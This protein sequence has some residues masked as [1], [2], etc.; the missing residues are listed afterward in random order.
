MY[1]NIEK[2]INDPNSGR[3]VKLDENLNFDI[4]INSGVT[5]GN[6]PIKGLI[7]INRDNIIVDGSNSVLNFNIYNT[8]T[9]DWSLFYISE[10]IENVEF[11]NLNINVNIINNKYSNRFFACVYNLS[12]GF[13]VNNCTIN[14]CSQTQL[15]LMGIYNNGKA[16][17]NYNYKA[18]N[19][20]ISNNTIRVECNCDEPIYITHSYGLLNWGANSISV[21]NNFIYSVIFGFASGVGFT[22]AILIFAGVRARMRFSNPPPSFKGTPIALITAGLIAMAFMGFSGMNIG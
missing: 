13:K 4:T 20:L 12:Y 14:V 9:S 16:S 6:L 1:K 18:D 5:V 8:E 17:V 11:R 19:L 2:V 22:M 15:S 3:V 21:Q 10:N 7:P